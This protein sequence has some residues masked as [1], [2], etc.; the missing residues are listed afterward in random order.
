[1]GGVIHKKVGLVRIENRMEHRAKGM[2][3]CDRLKAE[4]LKLQRELSLGSDLKI[5]FSGGRSVLH[6]K[7]DPMIFVGVDGC[8][9]E[10]GVLKIDTMLFS[11]R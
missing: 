2:A 9:K 6:K 5:D 4:T 8:K 1:M 7:V 11:L 3:Q 10:N